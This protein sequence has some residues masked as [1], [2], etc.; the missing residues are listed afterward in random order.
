MIRRVHSGCGC[1]PYLIIGLRYQNPAGSQQVFPEADAVWRPLS[2]RAMGEPVG[3]FH[4]PVLENGSG[5]F[6]M[7]DYVTLLLVNMVSA[8]VVLAFFL[9][10]GL[11]REHAEDWAPAFGICGLV[12]TIAGFAM[13]FT[14]PIP[15]PFAEIYGE[16]SVLLGVLFLGTAWAL[17]RGWSLLPL[18]IYAFVA[19]GAAVVIGV[20]IIHLGLTPAPLVP[21][22]GFILTGLGGVFAGLVLWK[23]ESKALRLA[24]ALV[25][26]AAAAIWAFTAV[27]AH[28]AHMKVEPPTPAATSWLPPFPPHADTRTS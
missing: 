19:G 15:K 18:S 13:S 6:P 26:L 23:H 17:T 7:I 24:G 3:K 12:A 22:A 10:W 21:G 2:H 11:G 25:M 9:W 20:R 4:V 28:W 27:T 8:L 5:R 16:A 14:W 1:F